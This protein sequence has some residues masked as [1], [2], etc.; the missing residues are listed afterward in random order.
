MDAAAVVLENHPLCFEEKEGLPVEAFSKIQEIF[1]YAD[2]VNPSEEPTLNAL[3]QR[4]ASN[5]VD[6]KLD[7]NSNHYT[8]NGSHRHQTDSKMPQEKKNEASCFLSSNLEIH[9]VS[10]TKQFPNN[11]MNKKEDKTIKV[12]ATTPQ[13]NKSN[14]TCQEKP[15]TFERSSESSNYVTD[16]KILNIKLDSSNFASFTSVDTSSSGS[17][18]PQTPPLQ[19]SL[20]RNAKKVRD[21]PPHM[22]AHPHHLLPWKSRRPVTDE[23]E[24]RSKDIGQSFT[25]S[26]GSPFSHTS[27]NKS[28]ANAATHSLTA[29]TSTQTPPPVS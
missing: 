7:T 12:D 19:P 22:E 29:V 10:S 16:S 14:I 5:I 27:I 24:S 28:P 21:S 13:P 8:E 6:Y 4:H 9:S 23:S 1:S 26:I 11:D 25:P 17:I 18:S 20:T 2:W 3:Q 15:K